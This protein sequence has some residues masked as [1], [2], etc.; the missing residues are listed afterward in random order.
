M[1]SALLVLRKRRRR[2]WRAEKAT[3]NGTA[4]IGK[5]LG[6]GEDHPI[7]SAKWTNPAPLSTYTITANWIS[8]ASSSLVNEVRFG[9]NLF[10]FAFVESDANKFANGKDYP[11]NTGIASTG[12]FPNVEISA[13]NSRA[14][15]SI[16]TSPTGAAGFNSAAS[17]DGKHRAVPVETGARNVALPS[18]ML[19][20]TNRRL[21]VVKPDYKDFSP[22]VDP[23]LGLVQQGIAERS[24]KVGHR[25]HASLLAWDVT[26]KGTTIVRGGSN[27][28]YSMFSTAKRFPALRAVSSA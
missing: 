22:R 23:A 28:L 5:Y 17:T 14:L 15:T 16:S 4:L 25:G 9:Y 18:T 10:D 7:V 19:P 13:A 6:N 12:G 21:V 20:P 26:G 11:L 1:K 24:G 3:V 8:T 27:V 2:F